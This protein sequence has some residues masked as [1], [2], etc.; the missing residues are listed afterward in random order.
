MPFN[1]NR[2]ESHS[3]TTNS[4]EQRDLFYFFSLCAEKNLHV[5]ITLMDF[6]WMHFQ[7]RHRQ[8]L[9]PLRYHL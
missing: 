6:S 2:T 9:H 1:S 3:I 4:P 7:H 5:E 8:Q